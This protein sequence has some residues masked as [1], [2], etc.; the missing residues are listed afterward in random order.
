MPG[1][2]DK[3]MNPDDAMM[4]DARRMTD[5]MMMQGGGRQMPPMQGG[6]MP[7]MEGGGAMMPPEAIA[8]LMQ[9][10]QE[11]GAVL[12]ARISN[13]SPDELRMLDSAIS[14]E[15]IRVLIKLLPELAQ[16]IEQVGAG[17][18]REMPQRGALGGM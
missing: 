7:P 16:I 14:P 9:P 15:V 12:M 17:G 10:S 8:R 5:E 18:A 11:I 2:M 3:D 13:M 4:A 1:H 6:E